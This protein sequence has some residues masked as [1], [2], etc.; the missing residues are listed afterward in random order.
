M[1]GKSRGLAFQN[2]TLDAPFLPLVI[3]ADMV[4]SSSLV[5]FWSSSSSSLTALD[6]AYLSLVHLSHSN[7]H[8][9]RD[10]TI[11]C[12]HKKHNLILGI[13]AAFQTR[14]TWPTLSS[15]SHLHGV[16]HA[17]ELSSSLP[18]FTFH[19]LGPHSRPS[20]LHIAASCADAKPSADADRH[21]AR[22]VYLGQRP[23]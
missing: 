8:L 23:V 19:I 13:I 12:A 21:A 20:Q 4:S 3:Y 7:D 17:H 15:C 2:G 6:P 16:S 9:T 18:F 1:S 11:M 5:S 14:S 22:Y 10:L